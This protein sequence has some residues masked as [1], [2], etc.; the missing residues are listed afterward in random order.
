MK[1]TNSI[2]DGNWNDIN[3]WSN[4]IPNIGDVVSVDHIIT[5]NSIITENIQNI[6]ISQKGLIRIDSN[7]IL[8]VE[9]L[10]IIGFSFECEKGSKIQCFGSM[11]SENY[12]EDV[13]L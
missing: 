8:N 5:M 10:V 6:Y 3:T 13:I 7:S 9:I 12:I 1:I 2:K 4:G 11:I